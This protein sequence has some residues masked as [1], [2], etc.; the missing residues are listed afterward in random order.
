M[1]DFFVDDFHKTVDRQVVTLLDDV[2]LRYP[3]TLGRPLAETYQPID[4]SRG[5]RRAGS[6]RAGTGANALRLI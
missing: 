3:K 2:R 1:V 5:F 4:V 6:C